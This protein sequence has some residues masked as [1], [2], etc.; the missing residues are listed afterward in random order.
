M[1]LELKN[2]I[3]DS[4]VTDATPLD[5]NSTSGGFGQ[6]TVTLP[7]QEGDETRL[8][9]E[10]EN[11]NVVRD[12]SYTDGLVSLTADAPLSKL[13]RW[14]TVAPYIGSLAGYLNQIYKVTGVLLQTTISRQMIIPGY[15]GNVWSKLKEFVAAY[16]W[17]ISPEGVIQFPRRNKVNPRNITTESWSVSTQESTEKVKLTWRNILRSGTN[18]E[19]FSPESPL[20]VDANEILVQDIEISGSLLRVNQPTCLDYVPADTDYSGTVGAYCVAGNDGKPILADRW[21]AGGGDLRVELTSDPGIIRII[22]IGSSVE[23]YAPYR[24]A[25]TSGTGNYYNSLHVTGGGMLWDEKEFT[26]YSGAPRSTDS[27]ETE[28]EVN[29]P[30]IV[31]YETAVNAALRSA[32]VQGGGLKTVTFSAAPTGLRV[33]DRMEMFG[34][35]HRVASLSESLDSVSV[36]LEADTLFSDWNDLH[37]N[38]TVAQ[39]NQLHDGERFIDFTTRSLR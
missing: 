34:G 16:G 18:T 35:V 2:I 1:D 23:E 31:D 27:A 28:V 8:E 38:M 14:H 33:G 13:N 37:N 21:K 15:E 20:S 11:G 39:F 4:K 32:R 12:I 6:Y 10:L 9:R 36:T 3:S 29:N 24:I 5:P 7:A 19:L 30:F 25:A 17:E 22:L 26:T